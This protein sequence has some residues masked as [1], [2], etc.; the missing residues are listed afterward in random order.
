MAM[1]DLDL[2]EYLDVKF[3]ALEEKLESSKD[4]IK[5][6]SDEIRQL[7]DMDRDGK[8][9]LR[10][11]ESFKEEHQKQHDNATGGKRF[12][13]EMWIVVAVC[14]VTVFADKLF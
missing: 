6:H 12:S 14:L 1:I 9:R 7:Y 2:K 11:L 4:D 8:E 13:I 5:R 10:T 3:K